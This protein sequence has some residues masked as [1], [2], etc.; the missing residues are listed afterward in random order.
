MINN[1]SS[2]AS[3]RIPCFHDRRARILIPMLVFVLS[4]IAGILPP[5]T[6]APAAEAGQS[7]EQ[8]DVRRLEGRWVRPDGGY[9]LDLRNIQI[10]GRVQ[11]AYFNPRRINVARAE[12]R[13]RNDGTIGLFI[14]LRD[15]NYPG[16]TYNLNYD[17]KSDRFIG[18]YFQAV[19][20]VTYDVEFVRSK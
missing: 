17:P 19:Q 20:K 6:G 8:T 3:A 15:V 13:F 1:T 12:L 16:S 14:E 11:A 7:Q 5:M 10:N 4:I 9:I 2:S 18:S